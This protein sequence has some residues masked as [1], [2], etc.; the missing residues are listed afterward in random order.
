MLRALTTLVLTV[1]FAPRA[2]QSQEDRQGRISVAESPP[3]AG[4]RATHYDDGKKGTIT[5]PLGDP[6]FADRLVS[7]YAGRPPSTK[8]L[9]QSAPL[10]PP[11]HVHGRQGG[12]ISLGCG[13][14]IVLEFADNVLVDVPG[15]DLHVFEI[16]TA[17]EGTLLE[18]SKDGSNWV[19]VGT[20]E[21]ATAS[22]DISTAAGPGD[23][24]GFVRLTDL[25]TAC[26]SDT[27]GADID[28][29]GAIG[30]GI[31]RTIEDSVLFGF[32]SST[33]KPSADAALDELLAE[34][35]QYPDARIILSGHTSSEGGDSYNQTLSEARA[36]AVKAY[37]SSKRSQLASR[38]EAVGFGERQPLAP[39]TTEIGREKNRRVEALII[40][41]SPTNDN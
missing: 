34:I 4:D 35:R 40:L 41:G 20:I 5:F 2:A 21:G 13:G 29:V 30:A 15:H 24:Y 33:L 1:T 26:A 11:D 23:S 8:P 18:I 28:A 14:N 6:S 27:S 38:I 12:F 19:E 3:A 7:R 37:L 9:I 10:G 31:K 36:S 39:N 22:V 17:E 32:D 16:G 25:E